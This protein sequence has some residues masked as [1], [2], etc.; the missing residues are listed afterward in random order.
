[1]RSKTPILVALLLLSVTAICTTPASPFHSSG[2]SIST[3]YNLVSMQT[4]NQYGQFSVN[5]TLT[6]GENSTSLSSITFGFPASFSSHLV[7]LS[8]YASLGSSAVQ[9]TTSSRLTNDSLFVTISF[10]RDLGGQNCSAGLGFWV[11]DSLTSVNNAGNYT[12][13]ALASPSVN[14]RLDTLNSTIDFPHQTTYVSNITTMQ[15]AGFA[16]STVYF[17]TPPAGQTQA[18][19]NVTRNITPSLKSLTISIYSD[20]ST[21]GVLDFHSITRQITVGSSGQILV[22]DT[23]NI[24]NLGLNT[25]SALSFTP[26]TTAGIIT[27]VP[28]NDPPLSNIKS[29]AISG[30]QLSLNSTNQQIQPESSATLIFQYPLADLYWNVTNGVYSISIPTSAPV[31]A[32]VDN[33]Q[34]FSSIVPG[35]ILIGHQI[36]LNGTFSSQIGAS[37]TTLE[38]RVGLASAS[39]TT[40]PIAVILFVAVFFAG[41]VFRPR[42][43][44]TVDVGSTFDNLIRTLEDK[45]SSTN[46]LLSE[47]QLRGAYVARNELVVARSRIDEVRA[48][49]TSRIS[50][51]RSQL[52]QT[53]STSVQ[54]GL[55]EILAYDREFDRVVRDILNNYDQL[56]SKRMK[57]DTFARVQQSNNRRLQ[58]TTNSLVDRVHDLREEYESEG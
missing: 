26:L 2:Q 46:D 10:E 15:N 48:K 16:S 21:T 40:L 31:D 4:F 25:I 9:T 14:L 1:M 3:G 50:T 44:E 27:V 23:L 6:G 8:S 54:V 55:N 41:L 5:E 47:L 18:W 58:S 24:Q 35:V 49:S 32:I 13:Q 12:G 30:D 17:T 52:P 19:E 7:S 57:E 29:V 33:Y 37:P 43:E 39:S 53:V 11:L 34:L 51:I 45:V 36:S 20:P 56:V 28:S 42:S 38:F 22:K